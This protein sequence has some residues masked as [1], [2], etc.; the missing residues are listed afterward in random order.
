MNNRPELSVI[1]VSYNVRSLLLDC[2]R[3]V[4]D[5]AVGIDCEIIVVDNLSAD[6]TVDALKEAVP[7]VRL[8]ANK[9]N[10]GF[11]RANNQGYAASKGYFVLLLNPDTIVKP[12][13]LKTMLEFMKSTPDA[14]MAGCRLLNPDG[15]LQKSI[16]TFPSVTEHLLRAFFLDRLVYSQ[17]RGNTY[18]RKAPFRIDYGT[19]AF[20][21]VRREALGDMQLLNP[22]FFMYAEEKDLALRLLKRGWH[23]C[24][25]PSAETIHYGGQSTGQMAMGMFLELQNSQVKFFQIHHKGAHKQLMIWTYWLVLASGTLASFLLSFSKYGRFRLKLFG[26]VTLR[27]PSMVIRHAQRP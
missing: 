13:A 24:F 23:T 10:A 22:D 20:L 1:I 11:A 9:E 6:G 27:Y 4:V 18:F 16:R 14:G 26:G 5:T 25:V 21:M 3:S 15:S 8:I 12:G 7:D 2:V 19:G 17:Y